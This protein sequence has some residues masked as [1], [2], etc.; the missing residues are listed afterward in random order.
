[1]LLPA[2]FSRKQEQ[3]TRAAPAMAPGRALRE[4]YGDDTTGGPDWEQNRS[5]EC[6]AAPQERYFPTSISRRGRATRNESDDQDADQIEPQPQ[7]GT[8][9]L[10]AA[11]PASEDGAGGDAANPNNA[12]GNNERDG[13][14][15][16]ELERYQEDADEEAE[17]EYEPQR[18]ENTMY[19]VR[20]VNAARLDFAGAT[21]RPC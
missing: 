19:C 21:E 4:S 20:R 13:D 17:A 6:R 10:R 1:M 14:G 3:G 5:A 16:R 7:R 8:E 18:G 12:E 11:L 15:G 9:P 2:P